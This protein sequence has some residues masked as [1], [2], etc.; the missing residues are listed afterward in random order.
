MYYTGM[1]GYG[2]F[3]GL[4]AFGRDYSEI[5]NVNELAQFNDHI[6]KLYGEAQQSLPQEKEITKLTKVLD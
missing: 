4:R 2:G 5:I 1:K 3:I 6:D